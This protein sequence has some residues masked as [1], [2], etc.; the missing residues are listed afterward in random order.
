M[1]L[2][3]VAL[4][5]TDA[6]CAIRN[7]GG[8][9][10]EATKAVALNNLFGGPS[11]GREQW[12]TEAENFFQTSLAR[13]QFNIFDFVRET[14][15]DIAHDIGTRVP[16]YAAN[17]YKLYKFPAEGYKNV[18]G[19]WF[20]GTNTFCVVLFLWSRRYSTPKQR[21]DDIK[22][23]G[24][25]GYHD[26]LWGTIALKKCRDLVL[27]CCHKLFAGCLW[28]GKMVVALVRKRKTPPGNALTQTQPALVSP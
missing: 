1:F 28:I 10:L 13:M 9:G 17:A 2:L 4:R 20:V 12:K 19:L 18:N 15:V 14:H 11:L 23:G 8:I 6:A 25:G 24:N 16:D 21:E 5:D 22:N 26:N 7:R 27:G 3:D